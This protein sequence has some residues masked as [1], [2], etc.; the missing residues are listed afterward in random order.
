[1]GSDKSIGHQLSDAVE[2]GDAEA[3]A[4]LMRDYPEKVWDDPET[5][6]R[7]RWLFSAADSGCLPII[8]LLV[9]AGADVNAPCMGHA[10]EG[11][12]DTA[13]SE[14]HLE[15]VRWLLDRGAVINHT[16]AGMP[17]CFALTGAAFSG[18]LDVVKLLV[19]RGA[20]I[21]CVWAGMTPLSHAMMY[22]Q[23]EVVDYLR[24]V[25]AKLPDELNP[26]PKPA[27]PAELAP[28]AP[29]DGE[30]KRPG[31][32]RTLFESNLPPVD[33]REYR[34]QYEFGPPATAEQLAA[35]E[36]ALGVTFPP[37]VR[38]MLS[39]FNGV[40]TRV[41]LDDGRESRDLA[42]LDLHTMTIR[43]PAY[44]ADSGNPLPPKK[45]LKAV[46]FVA[47]SNGFGDLWGVCTAAVGKHAAGAVVRL[48]HEVG[49]L[50]A[51]RPTLA[52]FVRA[53][54]FADGK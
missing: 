5:R 1:M 34:T 49:K 47:Q 37:D 51:C 2:A 52:A 39:E 18:H 33:Q 20:W 15:V 48:D 46:V 4:R 9:D 36:R 21:N 29:L 42:F 3:F 50:Q 41:Q 14:G 40:W 26:K 10:P 7:T 6:T 16:V 45:A 35:A 13:A 17:R 53:G 22:G 8:E 12:I 28:A 38:E 23:T 25:G 11:V 43:L 19:E 24:S 32:W 54:R 31:K 30:G 27:V 44:F